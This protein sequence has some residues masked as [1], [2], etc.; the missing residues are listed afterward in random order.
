MRDTP[1]I[2][3]NGDHQVRLAAGPGLVE[4]SISN[5]KGVC[6]GKREMGEGDHLS[7]HELG[8]TNGPVCENWNRLRLVADHFILLLRKNKC[9]LEDSLTLT[10]FEKCKQATGWIAL[11]IA[12]CHS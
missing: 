10:S 8:N 12:N 5:G 9:I 6:E 2:G 4:I 3:G 7:L 1:S 11:Q